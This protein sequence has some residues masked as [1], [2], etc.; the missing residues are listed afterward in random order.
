MSG[1]DAVEGF[2][3]QFLCT[4]EYAL[5]SWLTPD[6]DFT[7]VLVDSSRAGH[8]SLQTEQRLLA[9]PWSTSAWHIPISG[10]P[11]IDPVTLR[12]L[13]AELTGK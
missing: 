13:V 8:G 6:S 7:A 5:R 2:R 9:S 3:Y 12:A 4:L 11:E 10:L 1:A